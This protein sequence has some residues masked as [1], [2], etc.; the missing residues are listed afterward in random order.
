VIDWN[1]SDARI[2]S[3]SG[4]GRGTTYSFSFGWPVEA[5]MS[6]EVGPDPELQA[7][8]A[9]HF[10]L[11]L[12]QPLP[13]ELTPGLVAL[14]RQISRPQRLRIFRNVSRR[15]DALH[16]FRALDVREMFKKLR[17]LRPTTLLAMSFA[18][19][20]SEWGGADALAG[21]NPTITFI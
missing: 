15:A 11:P 20:R 14:Q 19:G 21:E 17:E 8:S 6:T 1:A 18:G 13:P 7:C 5:L 3:H 12:A 4:S 10:P 9:I 2:P 16:E